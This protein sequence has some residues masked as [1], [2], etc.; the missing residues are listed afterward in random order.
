MKSKTAAKFPQAREHDDIIP[1]CEQGSAQ[2]GFA[3]AGTQHFNLRAFARTIN[4]RETNDDCLSARGH[5][6]LLGGRL[7][8]ALE[9]AITVPIATPAPKTAPSLISKERDW[10]CFAGA[11]ATPAGLEAAEPDALPISAAAVPN[12][13]SVMLGCACGRTLP[14]LLGSSLGCV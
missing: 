10:C 8:L 14:G 13:R 12:G 4:A 2:S 7:G 1:K 6:W 5:Y 3:K 9:S 11:I